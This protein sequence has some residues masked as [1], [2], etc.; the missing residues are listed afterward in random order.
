MSYHSQDNMNGTKHNQK[1]AV[2]EQITM[3]CL[4][5][6][7]LG[8]LEFCLTVSF[9]FIDQKRAEGAIVSPATATLRL[10]GFFAVSSRKMW[11]YS[12]ATHMH[13][14]IIKTFQMWGSMAKTTPTW[15]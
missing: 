2:G 11:H 5:H 12:G 3:S 13:F 7:C 10:S 9:S 15:S 6:L 4:R 8:T 14:M 1:A